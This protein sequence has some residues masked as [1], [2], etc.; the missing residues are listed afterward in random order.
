M[1]PKVESLK[2]YFTKKP[3]IFGCYLD[4]RA[5]KVSF[6]VHQSGNSLH[7]EASVWSK[8]SLNTDCVGGT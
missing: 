4:F 1:N 2:S 8:T 6:Y 7:T 3:V 5:L